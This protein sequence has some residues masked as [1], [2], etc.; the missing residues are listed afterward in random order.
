M[1]TMIKGKFYDTDQSERLGWLEV[2]GEFK[3]KFERLYR[4]PEGEYFLHVHR[5]DQDPTDELIP[6]TESEKD[7]WHRE[8]M[9]ATSA[10]VMAK[11]LT[12]RNKK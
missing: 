9:I 8:I 1:Y 6:I 3:G 2:G 11:K 10:Y 12:E 4:T 5:E 7:E